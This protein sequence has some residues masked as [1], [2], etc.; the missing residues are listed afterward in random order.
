MADRLCFFLD[1]NVDLTIAKALRDRGV[2]VATAL[3]TGRCASSEERQ[4]ALALREARVLVTYDED[5]LAL[6]SNG[7][8]HAGIVY[9][10]M[11]TRTAS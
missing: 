11:G 7:V 4:L 10:R 9:A 2:D 8:P 5:F 3:E 6:H 1:Q